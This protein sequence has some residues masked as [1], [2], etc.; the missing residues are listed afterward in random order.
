MLRSFLAYLFFS[1]VLVFVVIGGTQ[2]FAKEKNSSYSPAVAYAALS[3]IQI[4][5]VVEDSHFTAKTPI[6]IVTALPGQISYSLKTGTSTEPVAINENLPPTA[7]PTEGVTSPTVVNIFKGNDSKTWQKKLPTVQ[8][9]VYKNLWPGVELSLN[10]HGNS[11]E[12]IFTVVPHADPA[13][14]TFSVEGATPILFPD[15]TLHLHAEKTDALFSKPVA[16]QMI[17]GV[18]HEVSVEYEV[19]GVSYGFILGAY[20][21]DYL[22]TIDPLLAG[23]YFGTTGSDGDGQVVVTRDTNTEDLYVALLTEGIDAP[24]MVGA[25][26]ET[27]GGGLDIL[28]ARFSSDLTMLKSATYLGGTDSDEPYSIQTDGSYIYVGGSTLSDDFPGTAGQYQTDIAGDSDAYISKLSLDLS[29]LIASTYLGGSTS[30]QITSMAISGSKLYVAGVTASGDFPIIDGA[31]QEEYTN[32]SG[33]YNSFISRFAL[34]NLAALEASTYLGGSEGASD[35]GSG[36]FDPAIAV[37]SSGVYVA[38]TVQNSDFPTT[39]GAYQTT[40]G[41]T[42][43]GLFVSKLSFDLTSLPASTF[44]GSNDSSDSETFGGIALDSS[45]RPYVTGYASGGGLA[46]AGAYQ[47]AFGGGED[48]FVARLSSD[49]SALQALTYLGGSGNEEALVSP[50][51]ASDGVYF[52]GYTN[53]DDFP[54]SVGAFQVTNP[55]AKGLAFVSKLS[56]NLNSLLGST[57]LGGSDPDSDDQYPIGITADSDNNIYVVGF[58]NAD[59]FPTTE[60][61]YDT[62]ANDDHLGDAFI[63]YMSCDLTGGAACSGVAVPTVAAT[64]ASS[65]FTAG[66]TF[67]SSLTATGGT[68]ATSRGFVYGFTSEYGSTAVTT[69]SYGVGAFSADVTGLI[70]GKTYHMASVATNS[71]GTSYGSDATFMT[72]PCGGGSFIG[73]VNGGGFGLSGLPKPRLQI[74]YPDGHVE[75]LD[76]Q[77]K[78][79][80]S[81]SLTTVAQMPSTQNTS[82]AAQYSFPQNR[83]VGDIGADIFL[84]QTFLNNH[85]FS[86]GET[87]PGSLGN[88]TNKFG[89]RTYV[90]LMQFQKYYDIPATG[91]FGPLTRAFMK[92]LKK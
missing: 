48:L 89:A 4:P 71:A 44:L 67:S 41:P 25:Y 30:D 76:E 42:S 16:Y 59:D 64:T 81:G 90:A 29:T 80:S 32:G 5:F 12:K 36:I 51:I 31:F 60:D 40:H 24:T 86:L 72:S 88:E 17:N 33:Q 9:V 65:I 1:L 58:T 69:G 54:V 73:S 47:I 18:K 56:L 85:G 68:N 15:G 55:D 6:G 74:V 45:D 52:A 22:L 53:S 28:I 10:A 84:L 7:F 11:V 13:S 19:K 8:N 43:P 38:G 46:T 79:Q 57:Y 27:S 66:A 26:Q 34:G 37:G 39:V 2:F 14:I 62:A 77:E 92:S 87:G 50:I 83:K 20:N 3:G 70:C 49:L 61:A 23:T 78:S 35:G 21:K 91:Y 63:A 82:V 75:Y